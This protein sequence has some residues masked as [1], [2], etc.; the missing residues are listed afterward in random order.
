[1]TKRACEIWLERLGDKDLTTDELGE[2]ARLVLAH[3]PVEAE[4]KVQ[5]LLIALAKPDLSM[6]TIMT[7]VKKLDQN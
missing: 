6:E 1:V 2:M 7:M 4:S 3:E 5:E